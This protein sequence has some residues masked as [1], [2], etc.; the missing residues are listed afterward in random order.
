MNPHPDRTSLDDDVLAGQAVYTDSSL[1][2]YDW[3]VLKISNRCIWKCP[4]PRLLK[5]YDDCVTTRHLD[6]GVGTGYFLDRCRFPESESPPTITLLDLNRASLDAAARRIERYS[7]QTVTANILEPLPLGEARFESISLNYLLHCIPGDLTEKAVA[8]NHLIPFLQP[9][10]II[11][12]STLLSQG[13]ERSFA[14]RKLMR[15]YNQKGIF[16]N[17]RDRLKDLER[18]LTTRFQQVQ[19]ETIGCAALFQ[20]RDPNPMSTRE[21]LPVVPERE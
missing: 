3:L 12:G 6:V 21:K 13:V 16:H 18:A 19:I 10:G 11:F 20:A 9:G 1:K 15:F 8:F 14:A 7:P 17:D 4:T 2:Y 5:M